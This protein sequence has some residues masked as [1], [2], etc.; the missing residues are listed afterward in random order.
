[1]WRIC[2]RSPILST[3]N[4][5][6]ENE[7]LILILHY[8]SSVRLFFLSISRIFNFIYCYGVYFDLIRYI[9]LQCLNR[10]YFIL[11]EIKTKIQYYVCSILHLLEFEFALLSYFI[12]LEGNF[13][14]WKENGPFSPLPLST[15]DLFIKFFD[16]LSTHER[17]LSFV[18]LSSLDIHTPAFI[19]SPFGGWQDDSGPLG[20]VPVP[21][22]MT[23]TTLT[24][25]ATTT[26]KMSTIRG[27]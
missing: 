1:M 13:F 3:Y 20:S 25:T 14:L 18:S 15:M 16:N 17:D 26:T 8:Y 2:L 9:G 27:R 11:I 4:Q 22:T 7:W 21:K 6:S 23:A 19:F 12:I 5:C 24:N 10:F